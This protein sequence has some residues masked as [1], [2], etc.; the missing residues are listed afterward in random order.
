[1][2][3][4]CWKRANS[5]DCV[6]PMA[7]IICGDTLTGGGKGFGSWPKIKPKS[8]WKKCPVSCVRG[9]LMPEGRE[10]LHT[11]RSEQQVFKMSVPDA[12]NISHDG[13]TG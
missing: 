12:K 8:T 13:I 1:M 7:S 4:S 11:I 3:Q 10:G 6:P 2:K 5:G 9:V